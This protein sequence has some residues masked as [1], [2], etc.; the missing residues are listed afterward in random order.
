[1]TI[2]VAVDGLTGPSTFTV[3][4]GEAS[5]RAAA[6]YGDAYDAIY[7]AAAVGGR[8]VLRIGSS[9]SA[10]WRGG[11]VGWADEQAQLELAR[12]VRQAIRSAQRGHRLRTTP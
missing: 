2:E 10:T 12:K 6:I 11:G 9:V 5:Q 3:T 7:E 8:I 1:M 4:P